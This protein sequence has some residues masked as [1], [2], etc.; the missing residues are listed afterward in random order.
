MAC[1][2]EIIDA[3]GA[4]EDK[5]ELTAAKTMALKCDRGASAE[6]GLLESK[7]VDAMRIHAASAPEVDAQ[8]VVQIDEQ[9]PGLA[10]ARETIEAAA[11]TSDNAQQ[12]EGNTTKGTAFEPDVNPSAKG[13]DDTNAVWGDKTKTS[14]FFKPKIKKGLVQPADEKRKASTKRTLHQ[15][16]PEFIGR[17]NRTKKMREAKFPVVTRMSLREDAKRARSIETDSQG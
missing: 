5:P 8:E 7:V 6:S 15:A 10:A 12:E 4:S 9:L 2:R 3:T 14:P 1:A 16:G 13:S 17:L 11:I